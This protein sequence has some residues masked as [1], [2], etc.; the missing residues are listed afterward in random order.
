MVA[1]TQPA[2]GRRAT[3]PN[4]AL[5]SVCL[6]LRGVAGDM[7]EL[8]EDPH[9]LV[10]VLKGRAADRL[11]VPPECQT[12][13]F[14]T[15][16]LEDSLS[17]A[18]QTRGV[19]AASTTSTEPA[20]FGP[21]TGD[22]GGTGGLAGAVS[23]DKSAVA[24]AALEITVVRTLDEVYR[25]L[26]SDDAG[27][28]Q[29]AVLLLAWAVSDD[30]ERAVSAVG[31][32]LQDAN[33]S[34]RV[35]AARVLSQVRKKK[36]SL[37][38][39][40][41]SAAVA[42]AQLA[43]DTAV[44][45][46]LASLEHG[47]LQVQREALTLLPLVAQ[48][49]D[50]RCLGRA[51][52]LFETAAERGN[53]ELRTDAVEA[54]VQMA[55]AGDEHVVSAFLAA[56]SAATGD[57]AFKARLLRAMGQVA[58]IGDR[59]AIAGVGV[60]LRRK[61]PELR[62]AAREAMQRLATRGD[63]AAIQAITECFQRKDEATRLDALQLLSLL[64]GSDATTI[65]ALLTLLE[66]VSDSVRKKATKLIVQLADHGARR[67]INGAGVR[68]RKR[69]SEV[70]KAARE[71][72]LNVT[73]RGDEKAVS[74]V[75][76]AVESQDKLV[77]RE[78][79]QLL[80]QV[81][82]TS[83][84]RAL[85]TLA[86][87]FADGSDAVRNAAVSAFIE[88]AASGCWH[89][90]TA[91]AARL[92]HSSAA[93]RQAAR[94]AL[95][96]V[97]E[98]GDAHA[99][100]AAIHCLSNGEDQVRLEAVALLPEVAPKGCEAAVHSIALRL[101]GDSSVRV[102]ILAANALPLV[103]NRGC[104]TAVEALCS[105]LQK[106]SREVRAA[107]R[108]ALAELADGGDDARVATAVIR[109]L[110]G[111][112]EIVKLD[113]LDSFREVS[114]T[115]NVGIVDATCRCLMDDNAKVRDA[116]A[117]AV[118]RLSSERGC[119]YVVESVRALLEHAEEDVR[120]AA[121]KALPLVVRRGDQE[122]VTSALQL[123]EQATSSELMQLAAAE[124]LA[125][126]AST[127]DARAIGAIGD[128][129]RSGT[130]AL[131]TAAAT[132]LP[133]LAEP[134]DAAA[135]AV[136][137]EA[138]DNE[139]EAVRLAALGLLQKMAKPGDQSAI[140][141][142]VRLLDDPMEHVRWQ[143]LQAMPSIAGTGNEQARA[144]ATAFLK[145][146]RARS[147]SAGRKASGIPQSPGTPGTP[148]G[149]RRRS[150]TATMFSEIARL[151]PRPSGSGV[152]AASA[153]AAFAAIVSP[154][155]EQAEDGMREV[156]EQ[157]FLAYEKGLG[158]RCRTYRAPPTPLCPKRE[159]FRHRPGQTPQT[160]QIGFSNNPA[161][162]LFSPAS[163]GFNDLA[164][165]AAGSLTPPSASPHAD[166][167]AL[168]SRR[169]SYRFDAPLTPSGAASLSDGLASRLSSFQV[170]ADALYAPA[171][172]S[173]SSCVPTEGISRRSSVQ[174]EGAG[175]HHWPGSLWQG[176]LPPPSE[177]VTSRRS[178][179]TPPEVHS[180][181]ARRQC[182]QAADFESVTMSVV[183]TPRS[184][185]SSSPQTARGPHSATVDAAALRTPRATPASVRGSSAPSAPSSRRSTI[186]PV[187]PGTGPGR[188]SPEV[189][190]FRDV[191]ARLRA[192]AGVGVSSVGSSS[193]SST[194]KLPA[195]KTLLPPSKDSPFLRRRGS[196]PLPYSPR[197]REDCGPRRMSAP[198]LYEAAKS[199]GGGGPG[200]GS[201]SAPRRASS[202]GTIGASAK[203]PSCGSAT[204]R[205]SSSPALVGSSSSATA[206]QVALL[207]SRRRGGPG[208]NGVGSQ[209]ASSGISAAAAASNANSAPGL[210]RK[211]PMTI[212][213]RTS[214]AGRAGS[215]SNVRVCITAR[216][217]S[218]G[219]TRR[220]QRP[221]SSG[222]LPR[223]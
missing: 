134:G 4:A 27:V 112:D 208:C 20:T 200:T 71:V 62:S 218:A 147:S 197:G 123:L 19:A 10:R 136:I 83:D 53:G 182:F 167:P 176:S 66:D 72:L 194:S 95:L 91:A 98:P 195:E 64:G 144:G 99:I 126:V 82:A 101:E 103:A 184:L 88:I 121:L 138:A 140:D 61:D 164:A 16:V 210:Q 190:T 69:R 3:A 32:R 50:E 85:H 191:D 47:T 15:V 213:S 57:E 44:D 43:Y 160:P 33:A 202:T 86:A 145:S 186:G 5:P 219:T 192:A 216:P 81:A 155:P 48:R 178:S 113:M 185:P 211:A 93:V 17:L 13:V 209:S 12:W 29:K 49:G 63:A 153:S 175:G 181:P 39:C 205:G 131:Q 79:V 118:A 201:A 9:T 30:N 80:P 59:K 31:A 14:G 170:Q 117:S 189:C 110:E 203:A 215:S 6:K 163:A 120:M 116:A 107:A 89:A 11:G 34:V 188:T 60:C 109:C 128:C 100:R 67:V 102:R 161:D 159:P 25:R 76:A 41:D 65:D 119:E 141:V 73:S 70:R 18:A 36:Q 84:E 130:V 204:A 174:V 217:C 169:S 198:A 143:A 74:A 54:L 40:D 127:G 37:P 87:A 179:L 97:V 199:V 78:A 90:V 8:H 38:F 129:L 106:T 96:S 56:L 156:Y 183:E 77:R 75:I 24:R 166:E 21:G 104:N 142:A 206:R 222:M 180:A 42:R 1:G 148:R 150:S 7:V 158:E 162:W 151:S 92:C 139:D 221:S 152:S 94:T 46:V 111:S 58:T 23:Q 52:Q 154:R 133:K 26:Q 55:A 2:A 214:P 35:A 115:F 146:E 220:I 165:M 187:Y 171:A 122:A 212:S 45:A 135:M 172:A 177:P 173:S 124:C 114:Q 51:L 105:A 132:A 157:R 196:E 168:S 223:S 207:A 68:L 108:Q 125:D 22:D 193:S 137:A 149:D 28:R